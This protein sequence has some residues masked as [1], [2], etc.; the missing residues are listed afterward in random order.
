[1]NF[2]VSNET[3]VGA[4]TAIAITVLILGYNFLKGKNLFTRTNTYYAVYDRV[5]GLVN[6]NPVTVKGY[7]VG[8]IASISLMPNDSMKVKVTIEVDSDVAVGDSSIA[9]IVSL[10]LLGSKAIELIPSGKPKLLETGSMLIGQTEP[11]LMS[12]VAQVAE[13]L[14]VKIENILVSLDSVF[15]GESGQ[16]LQSTISN[17]DHITQ[18]FKSTSATLDQ[19]VAEQS[20][21][22]DEIFNN[23]L[24][25]SSNLKNNNENINAAIT[26]LRRLSDTLAAANIQQ[27]VQMCPEYHTL[28][29]LYVC[30]THHLLHTFYTPLKTHSCL[31]HFFLRLLHQIPAVKGPHKGAHLK[32]P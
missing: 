26:N 9:K 14:K 1:M 7:R 5:D 32:T 8:Q 23:V 11:S 3:K 10:D 21:R 13:P 15:G 25:I 20:K 2:K 31:N 16:H 29:I 12:S 22:L 27:V 18:N 28:S 6:S 30:V 17:I 4:L 24:S 19:L